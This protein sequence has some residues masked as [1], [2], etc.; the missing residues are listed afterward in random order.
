VGLAVS[1]AVLQATLRGHLPSHLAYLADSTYT[2]PSD[3]SLSVVDRNTLLDSYMY[4]SR[5]V[6][7]LQ[8]PLIGLCLFGCL[9]IKDRGLQPIEDEVNEDK[10]QQSSDSEELEQGNEPPPEQ[11]CEKRELAEAKKLVSPV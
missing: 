3:L 2:L 5:A 11:S 8:V 4:A 7:I 9:M 1:A 10:S 6:F